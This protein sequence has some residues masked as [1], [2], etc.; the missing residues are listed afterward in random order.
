MEFSNLNIFIYQAFGTEDTRT[1]FVNIRGCERGYL[2]GSASRVVQSREAPLASGATQQY[3]QIA[4]SLRVLTKSGAGRVV[5]LAHSAGMQR[6]ARLAST[7]FGKNAP[8]RYLRNEFWQFWLSAFHPSSLKKIMATLTINGKQHQ[9]DLSDDTPLLWALRDH[10]G[11]TGT[12]FG[13]G[14]A[15]CGACTCLLYTSPSPRDS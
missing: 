8:R 13:C 5:L 9:M 10:L 14:M 1:H 7:A 15:L 4:S 12:K 3:A 2:G 11:M 6:V